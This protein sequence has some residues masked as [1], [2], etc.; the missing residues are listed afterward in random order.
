MT[1]TATQ[2]PMDV[3]NKAEGLDLSYS[4]SLQD[5]FGEV[6]FNNTGHF[7]EAPWS[8][9]DSGNS[10]GPASFPSP[11]L[12]LITPTASSF[13]KPRFLSETSTIS[14]PTDSLACP[15]LPSHAGQAA[16]ETK[17]DHGSPGSDFGTGEQ[18]QAYYSGDN[19]TP[20]PVAHSPSPRV[21]FFAHDAPFPSISDTELLKIE[22]ISLQPTTRILPCST[23]A[24]PTATRQSDD[25]SDTT[26][27]PSMS[28]G[29]A[30]QLPEK[31]AADF[32]NDELLR[33]RLVAPR[34]SSRAWSTNG[35]STQPPQKAATESSFVNGS[36]GNASRNPNT[37]PM[38]PPP[39]ARTVH[40]QAT[41]S[42]QMGTANGGMG[43]PG[44]SYGRAK[45][46]SPFLSSGTEDFV[47]TDP[48]M[49]MAPPAAE[50]PG[51]LW[52]FQGG[53]ASES[54]TASTATVR[55]STTLDVAEL[56]DSFSHAGCEGLLSHS[57][58]SN[59]LTPDLPIYPSVSRPRSQTTGMLDVP[60]S[61][62]MACQSTSLPST[63]AQ[64]PTRSPS[65]NSRKTTPMASPHGKMHT[66]RGASTSPSPARGR[67]RAGEPGATRSASAAGDS[68]VRKRQSSSRRELRRPP[69]TEN[70]GFVN[71]T[72][73]DGHTLMM[74]VAPSGS[75]KTKAKRERE[76]QERRK[77]LEERAIKAVEAAGGDVQ[78]LS[79]IGV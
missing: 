29:S 18:N 57:P 42:T 28:I 45:T 54:F 24:S 15:D 5:S 22:G 72:A 49:L 10:P 74:G 68:S 64:R 79:L 21:P 65:V 36:V 11:D 73:H 78:L 76:E 12:L 33:G 31:A 51:G 37:A 13:N 40:T 60:Y 66:I 71:F 25:V 58:P 59:Y 70:G 26:F 63:P 75:S 55:D 3:E 53:L 34:A 43:C 23:P 7:G 77:K 4:P 48:E 16:C 1:Y 62:P 69:S 30:G 9:G 19:S 47:W 27:A 61:S 38:P 32:D 20:S 52:D 41:S 56:T 67:L 2:S 8:F 35:L 17:Q 46:L 44:A 39:E 50:K 14:S 6:F